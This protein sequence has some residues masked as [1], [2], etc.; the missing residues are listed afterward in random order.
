MKTHTVIADS[1]GNRRVTSTTEQLRIPASEIR[2]GDWL[3]KPHR[4][5]LRKD[6]FVE[7]VVN[8]GRQLMVNV[9]LH[10]PVFLMLDGL[11]DVERTT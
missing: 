3:L 2:P 1:N 6:K 11:V 5:G 7:S 4:R 9:Q 10:A 8:N